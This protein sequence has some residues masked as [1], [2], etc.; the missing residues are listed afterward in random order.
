VEIQKRYKLLERS[1]KKYLSRKISK[2]M[3]KKK[4]IK[5]IENFHPN[6][7]QLSI[8]NANLREHEEMI[9]SLNQHQKISK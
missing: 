7:F 3:N 8:L 1:L 6:S 4:G 5:I 9:D 2:K